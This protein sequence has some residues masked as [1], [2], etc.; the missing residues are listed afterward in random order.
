M[1]L[2][3]KPLAFTQQPTAKNLIAGVKEGSHLKVLVNI[4]DKSYVKYMT[5]PKRIISHH[6]CFAVIN[7]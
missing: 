6:M 7:F 2:H 1:Y 5:N 3:N 4:L